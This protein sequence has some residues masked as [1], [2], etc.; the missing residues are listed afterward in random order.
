MTETST[1]KF[2]N[3]I[4]KSE[5]TSVLGHGTVYLTIRNSGEHN[6]VLDILKANKYTH[7]TQVS[8]NGIDMYYITTNYR[9]VV[10][11]AYKTILKSI[12][13]KNHLNTTNDGTHLDSL[14]ILVLLVI[15]IATQDI[16]SQ[17]NQPDTVII[18]IISLVVLHSVVTLTI[19]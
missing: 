11:T 19:Q 6:D 12:L 1:E 13:Y 8:K 17:K 9:V 3:S 4:I 16:A 18:Q 14:Q 15:S 5:H 10:E 7:Y 2:I